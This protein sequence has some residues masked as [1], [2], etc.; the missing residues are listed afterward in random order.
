M[1]TAQI[2][3]IYTGVKKLQ[4]CSYWLMLNFKIA[5]YR[6]SLEMLIHYNFKTCI[7]NMYFILSD[8]D[9][10]LHL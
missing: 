5:K 9:L 6:F 8:K 4:A 3:N 1:I 10:K 7:S 2:S